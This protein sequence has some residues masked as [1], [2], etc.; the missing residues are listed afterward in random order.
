MLSEVYA[1]YSKQ[2]VRALTLNAQHVQ[3]FWYY[4]TRMR[5]RDEYFEDVPIVVYM[6]GDR[7]V[8]R[9]SR[10]LSIEEFLSTYSV[11]G[12]PDGERQK[13]K[14]QVIVRFVFH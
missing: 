6:Q 7:R 9:K 10:L 13:A 12:V 8:G 5:I 4:H 1:Q 14:T 2:H 11:G 3:D